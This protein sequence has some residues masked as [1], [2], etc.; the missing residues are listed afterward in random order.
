MLALSSLVDTTERAL[1]TEKP[2]HDDDSITRTTMRDSENG[3]K[4]CMMDFDKLM[5]LGGAMWDDVST[6]DRHL[7]PIE[8][9]LD[10]ELPVPPHAIA[11]VKED[12]SVL[13]KHL[14]D[15]EHELTTTT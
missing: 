3:G 15:L 8:E 1:V 10:D 11:S 2:P 13:R 12:I 6:L 4:T 9:L 5:K 7:G 14:D